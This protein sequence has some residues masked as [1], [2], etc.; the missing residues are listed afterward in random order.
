MKT[1]ALAVVLCAAATPG[2]Y[3]GNYSSE[4]AGGSGALRVTLAQKEEAW[5]AE[6]GFD[7]DGG[8]VACKVTKVEVSGDKALI[9]YRFELGGYELES[10]LTG[11]VDG[12]SFNGTYQTKSTDGQ[13]ID[14]GSFQTRRKP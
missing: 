6:A 1:A 13:G 9:A 4:G 3:E 10:T 2:K 12:E 11:T 8:Q 14:R 5:T 7:Y